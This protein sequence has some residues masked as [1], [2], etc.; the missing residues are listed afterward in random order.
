ML[1][2]ITKQPQTC[3]PSVQRH[4]YQHYKTAVTKSK[5]S[6]FPINVI[7]SPGRFYKGLS[8]NSE[9]AHQIG[10]I[11]WLMIRNFKKSFLGSL[12]R[13]GPQTRGF[14][15]SLLLHHQSMTLLILNNKDELIT[16]PF[17]TEWRQ[18]KTKYSTLE[19]IHWEFYLQVFHSNI[20]HVLNLLIWFN[21]GV[22]SKNMTWLGSA[23]RSA[24]ADCKA[25]RGYPRSF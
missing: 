3:K 21:L 17:W 20:L 23:C 8:T 16:V 2:N 4:A 18:T 1:T 19:C 6:W 5:I 13:F 9:K 25:D 24:T 15:L 10:F 11:H 12:D 14:I 7:T 22:S